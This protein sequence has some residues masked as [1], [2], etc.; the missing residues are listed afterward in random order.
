[1]QSSIK[2]AFSVRNKHTFL[3]CFE[4]ICLFQGE[5]EMRHESNFRNVIVFIEKVVQSLNKINSNHAA[6]V[7]IS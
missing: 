5:Y 7:F 3:C 6:A 4:K 2:N 1:M